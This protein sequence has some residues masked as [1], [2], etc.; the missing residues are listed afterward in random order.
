MRS[1]G[2]IALF[3]LALLVC[4]A[5][6]EHET[7]R[8]RSVDALVSLLRHVRTMIRCYRMPLDEIYRGAHAPELEGLGFLSHLRETANLREALELS[9]GELL[10]SDE[11]RERLGE[12]SDA[13]GRGDGESAASLC[14]Y[15][16]GE[17]SREAQALRT[18]AP[19]RLRLHR[20]LVVTG[21]LMLVI[22]FI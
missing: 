19:K 13:V 10:L 14:D 20:S 17:L 11:L 1:V 6:S 9:R 22:V 18:A 8:L 5:L 7:R 4:R 16:I 12:L 3:A 21:M 15:Y 2:V